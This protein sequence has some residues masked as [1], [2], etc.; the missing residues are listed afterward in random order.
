MRENAKKSLLSLDS[1][2]QATGGSL[3]ADSGIKEQAAFGFSYV[4]TDSRY[5]TSDAMFVPLIGENQNGHKYI[6]QALDAGATVILVNKSDYEQNNDFYYFPQQN[7]YHTHFLHLHLTIFQD[8]LL[9]S[10]NI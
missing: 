10:L 9:L 6:P 1:L 2:L 7:Q 5:V 3:M 8:N 4:V